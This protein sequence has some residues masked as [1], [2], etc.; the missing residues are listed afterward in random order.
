MKD[1]VIPLK[2][3]LPPGAIRLDGLVG[4]ETPHWV[5]AEF[6]YDGA[7]WK[8][9]GDTRFEPLEIAYRDAQRSSAAKPFKIGQTK[10]Q[11]KLELRD[12]LRAI[13]GGKAAYLYAYSPL[14]PRT[15]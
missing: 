10:T 14:P 12:D 8:V 15:P 9:A 1:F 4:A 2:A 13:Q 3:S 6:D 5:M 11:R 7:T